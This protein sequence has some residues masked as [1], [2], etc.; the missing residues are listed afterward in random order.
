M[1]TCL[2]EAQSQVRSIM[3]GCLSR[4]PNS[5]IFKDYV[6]DVD[7]PSRTFSFFTHKQSILVVE[8]DNTTGKFICKTLRNLIG[9]ITIHALTRE[10]AESALASKTFT[11][12]VINLDLEYGNGGLELMEEFFCNTHSKWS[13]FRSSSTKVIGTLNR[14]NEELTKECLQ[15]GFHAVLTKP[16]Q[17]SDLANLISPHHAMSMKSR[18]F[19]LFGLS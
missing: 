12:I 14:A 2:K 1:E 9:C 10:E 6:T 5:Q 16:Y 19:S 8:A 13:A 11:S 7:L 17:V 3:V 18:K 15:S 4:F